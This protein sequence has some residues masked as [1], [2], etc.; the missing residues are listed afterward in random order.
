MLAA[1][2]AMIQVQRQDF[3]GRMLTIRRDDL[4][5][6]AC[7]LDTTV[8]GAAP[9]ARRARLVAAARVRSD[10]RR[11]DRR[12]VRR[13]R[14][15]A[16]LRAALRLLRVRH[17]DR[18]RPPDGATTSAACRA[19]IGRGADAAAGDER[20]LR[21]RHAVA[22]ARRRCWRRCSTRC[23]RAPAPRSPSSATPTPSPPSC[24]TPTARAGVNRLSFGVQSMVPHVLARSAAPT[25]RPT[26]A[27]AVDAGSRRR[28]SIV[29]PRPDLRRRR[30]SRS[31]DWAP[32][33]DAVL[34]LDPPHVS[35]YALTVEPGTPLAADPARHPDDD[36]QADKYLLADELLDRRRPGR[37]RD[38]QLGPA[39]PRVPAQPP[40][41]APGRLP[42]LRLRRPLATAPA[43][44]GG[45]C[46]RPS[47]TSPRSHR[48]RSPEA[49]DEV[50]DDATRALERLQL[51]LRTSAGVPR[52]ALD[53]ADAL[54]GLVAPAADAASRYPPA[55]GCW[56]TKSRCACTPDVQVGDLS[57]GFRTRSRTEQL[58]GR[59]RRTK[60][61]MPKPP[62]KAAMTPVASTKP[63]TP[64]PGPL[65]STSGL[66]AAAPAGRV[67]GVLA[68][69]HDHGLH[70]RRVDRAEVAVAARFG[71]HGQRLRPALAERLRS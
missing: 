26:C 27:R 16:V 31:T 21:R 5:A 63:D 10:R 45:T 18:P 52:A 30:A 70:G 35:A 19:E 62:R 37:L 7:I 50:L 13:L 42:R 64:P 55:A 41:L 43:A 66:A 4:R 6:I 71:G 60:A 3:N 61:L 49:A 68:D 65:L 44:A 1:T 23:P 15:R 2:S 28:A 22:A 33:L 36:D 17:V 54:A 48:A 53:D 39:R 11:Y 38:L 9:P 8:D 69:H 47:A 25:T 32:T 57:V 59:R 14:P 46:A 24:S 58:G 40:V 67:G 20:V 29:Q 51:A 56:P 34:A 12:P